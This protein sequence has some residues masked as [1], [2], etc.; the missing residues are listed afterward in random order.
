MSDKSRGIFWAIICNLLMSM[1]MILVR[2]ATEEYHPFFVVLIRNFLALIIMIIWVFPNGFIKLKT[3]KL[4]LHIFR[5]IVG[6][7]AMLC[8]FYALANLKLS[9]ATALSFTAPVFTSIAAM[10][11]LKEKMGLKRWVA[12]IIGFIG[13]LIIINPG[14]EPMRPVVLIVLFS[15]MLWAVAAIIIKKMTKT[16]SALNITFYMTLFMFPLSIPFGIL[17]YERINFEYFLIF[18]AIA[19][20]SNIAHYALSKAMSYTDLVNILPIDFSKLIFIAIFSF[21]LFAEKITINEIIGSLI[22]ITSSVYISYREK[23]RKIK[24]PIDYN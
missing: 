3:Q 10:I 8:W 9:F 24:T 19:I 12:V 2:I 23:I 18:L 4:N 17:Y 14:Y 11:F 5:S 15:T 7:I 20:I 16:E 1:M 21:I 13:T 22:I 6:I